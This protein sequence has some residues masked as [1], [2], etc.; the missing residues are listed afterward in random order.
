MLQS[1]PKHVIFILKS[2]NFSGEG[3]QPPPPATPSRIHSLRRLDLRAFGAHSCTPHSE[4][5]LRACDGWFTGYDNIK[6]IQKHAT[7][8]KCTTMWMWNIRHFYVTR[9]EMRVA[10]VWYFH[11]VMYIWTSV[12][13]RLR[14]T[15]VLSSSVYSGQSSN[16]TVGQSSVIFLTHH[17]YD[18]HP[19]SHCGWTCVEYYL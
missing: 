15:L 9:S 19:G 6:I 4:V 8:Y 5:W 12:Y 3:A 7:I 14:C 10:Q 16:T 17:C 1:S 13:V 18:W 2:Q 11:W